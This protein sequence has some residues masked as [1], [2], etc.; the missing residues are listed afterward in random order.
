[1]PWAFNAATPQNFHFFATTHANHV[2]ASFLPSYPPLYPMYMY[3][4]FSFYSL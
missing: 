2:I 3:S 4:L 1:V